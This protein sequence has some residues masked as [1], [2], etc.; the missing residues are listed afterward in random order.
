[1]QNTHWETLQIRFIEN[2]FKIT[3][4]VISTE[5]ILHRIG[6]WKTLLNKIPNSHR[7]VFANPCRIAAAEFAI[8]TT[9]GP[10]LTFYSSRRG[11]SFC[12]GWH[13]LCNIE[14]ILHQRAMKNTIFPPVHFLTSELKTEGQPLDSL[15]SWA[16]RSWNVPFWFILISVL[17]LVS[18]KENSGHLGR[19]DGRVTFII[20]GF[21][22]CYCAAEKGRLLKLS[23]CK[24]FF[25]G[26]SVS[27]FHFYCK[28]G[29]HI[30][31]SQK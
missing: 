13:L 25:W 14:Y 7:E 2:T 20:R 22:D 12:C 18:T 17:C 26:L 29:M 5:Y 9:E 16:W 11:R 4:E 28:R 8:L 31:T 19:K 15:Y 10:L 27:V 23:C 21:T 30:V 1:M 6:F 24:T 3:T